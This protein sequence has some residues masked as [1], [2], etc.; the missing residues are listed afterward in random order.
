MRKVKTKKRS[1]SFRVDGT[2]CGD[3][4]ELGMVFS[5]GTKN[6]KTAIKRFEAILDKL[7]KNPGR[8]VLR[9]NCTCDEDK[10]E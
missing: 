8:I 9:M 1:L 5:L 3:T 4:D 6:H 2:T 7:G 10:P